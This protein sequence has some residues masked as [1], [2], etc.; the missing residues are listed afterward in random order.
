METLF[1]RKTYCNFGQ[2][3]EKDLILF[4]SI[5]ETSTRV[6]AGKVNSS[7]APKRSIQ[8]VVKKKT[9][10]T[11]NPSK[12]TRKKKKSQIT[13][14]KSRKVKTTTKTK[15][16]KRVEKEKKVLFWKLDSDEV[17]KKNL[18]TNG[19]GT[20]DLGNNNITEPVQNIL[21]GQILKFTVHGDPK[22]LQRHRLSRGFVYN[23]SAPA[24]EMFKDV[25]RDILDI[26][27]DA[28]QTFFPENCLLTA[29][30]KFRLKR[31]QKHFI[32]T[33][34]SKK[35]R[36]LRENA[37]IFVDKTPDIDNLTKFV[38]DSLNNLVYDDDRQI[39]SLHTIK[40]YD[41]EGECM[42]STEVT[43]QTYQNFD[44]LHNTG[45]SG[46]SLIERNEKTVQNMFEMEG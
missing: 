10:K 3:G 44:E 33:K 17:I 19:I 8:N 42:G 21:C 41:N 26:P 22:P 31:P 9:K 7:V 28:T 13:S 25:V 30:L 38:L 11:K 23:P 27:E 39:I 4:K 32:G 24:Q 46:I 45:E 2:C 18:L 36:R 20:S 34:Q 40:S 14:K 5:T 6:N 29:T 15:K 43:L 1:T 12:K 37:P 35:G 16:I